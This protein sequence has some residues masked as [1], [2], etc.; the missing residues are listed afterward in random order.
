MPASTRELR[1][2]IRSIQNTS[3][4]TKAMQLIAASK[5]RRAQEM[6]LS[7]RPYAEKISDVLADLAAQIRTLEEAGD[8]P[9]VPLFEARQVQKTAMVL[10]TPDRGLCGGLVANMNRAAGEAIRTAE[11]P[12]TVISVGRKGRAFI[13][14]IGGDLKAVFTGIGDRPRLEDTLQ[15]S[16]IVIKEFEDRAVDR[17]WL[18]YSKFISTAQQTPTIQTLIPVKPAELKPQEA[19]GYIYEPDAPTVLRRLLPR[20]V[21]MEVYHA[22]LEAI[23]SE[24]SARMVAMK[25][26]TDAA[27]EL[28]DELRL[29]LN[30]ARQE[31]ITSEI[32][33]IV[34]G[35]AGVQR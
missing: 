20:Y 9:I 3:Q 16:N 19:V 30:K 12:V 25:N 17:V 4:I 31:S 11:G 18:A 13:V 6:V 22:I 29:D 24:H 8:G 10:L 21:Q 15:I 26:A 23:A 33:D 27:N 1:R 7:G 34:G 14:R 5:M 32:L 28:V 2:R 35:V